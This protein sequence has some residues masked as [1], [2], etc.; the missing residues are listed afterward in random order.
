MGRLTPPTTHP[1]P[2]TSPFGARIDPITG[3]A[4]GHDGIDLG[5]PTGTPILAVADGTVY[6]L[7][8]DADGVWDGNGN[9]VWLREDSGRTWG[10]LHLS[11]IDRSVSSAPHRGAAGTGVRVR[12][13]QVLGLSGSTGR[14]TG[15]HLHL[16]CWVDG[17]PADPGPIL[18]LTS[19][20]P[21]VLHRVLHRGLTGQDVGLLQA[22][23]GVVVDGDFGPMTEAAVR[24]Y[25]TRHGLVVDGWVGPAT[26]RALGL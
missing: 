5:C 14:S 13:G 19:T 10:Y 15:P 4:A 2:V 3:A 8:V 1:W 22:A 18:G 23:L 21:R 26:R 7:D 6:R 17:R 25:Q 24:A 20:A 11:A 9:A 16:G 12:A